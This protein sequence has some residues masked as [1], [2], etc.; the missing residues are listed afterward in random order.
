MDAT[1]IL[2]YTYRADAYC[3][4][5]IVAAVGRPESLPPFGGLNTEDCLAQIAKIMGI[6]RDDESS[7][8][9]SWFPKPFSRCD[10][11]T[12]LYTETGFVVARG[13]W[14]S[15]RDGYR[16]QPH[17]WVWCG[18]RC[19]FG[20]L[21]NHERYEALARSV[22]AFES[23]RWYDGSWDTFTASCFPGLE[24]RC[25]SCGEELP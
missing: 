11:F 15:P 2:G 8:A 7:F 22:E 14:N 9:S 20:S 23:T 13:E 17:R 6:D 3:P 24:R 18:T 1:D 19:W 4:A 12:V 10:T 5:C 21:P 25:G 16:A